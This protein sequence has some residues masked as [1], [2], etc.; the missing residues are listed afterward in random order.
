MIRIIDSN[1]CQ[2]F[3]GTSIEKSIAIA[4][5]KD[6]VPNTLHFF[7]RKD[8]VISVGRFTDITKFDLEY[9]KSKNILILRRYTGGGV[10]YTDEYQLLYALIIKQKFTVNDL[11]DIVCS[12]VVEI[13][14]NYGLKA[15]HKKPNDV[16]VNG[17]KISGNAILK[18]GNTYL[19]DGTIILDYPEDYPEMFFKSKPITS[20]Y[21][22]LGFKVT[23]NEIKNKFMKCIKNK[24]CTEIIHGNLTQYE[25]ILTKDLLQQLQ[26]NYRK[27][28]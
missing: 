24:L 17:R 5:E 14:N 12:I 23:H 26:Q 27:C 1:Y 10:I 9:L 25:L 13:L 8:K 4:R 18:L 22:Q 15:Q 28:L 2:G 11:F 3:L 19:L 7:I 6:I 20:L 16:L 21:Q